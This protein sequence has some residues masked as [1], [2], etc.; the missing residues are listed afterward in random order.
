MRNRCMAPKA[1]N[2]ERRDSWWFLGVLWKHGGWTD[3]RSVC[4]EGVLDYWGS[5]KGYICRFGITIT[6][7][8]VWYGFKVLEWKF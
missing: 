5:T 4:F 1:N 8:N 2:T 6:V 7:G 3:H